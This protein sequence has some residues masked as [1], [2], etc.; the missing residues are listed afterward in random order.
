MTMPMQHSRRLT[1]STLTDDLHLVTSPVY[2]VTVAVGDLPWLDEFRCT[3]WL[4][5]PLWRH[6]LG[7][8]GFAFADGAWR[9]KKL[10][11]LDANAPLP[12]RWLQ[13]GS[14]EMGYVFDAVAGGFSLE[15]EKHV[16]M[17]CTLYGQPAA[18][19]NTHLDAQHATGTP[20]QCK[21][22]L[23]IG[24]N[25]PVIAVHK[26]R[27][28]LGA[29]IS[30]GILVG[31]KPW[32]EITITRTSKSGSNS[33]FVDLH[34]AWIAGHE[35]TCELEVAVGGQW[36]PRIKIHGQLAAPP[37]LASDAIRVQMRAYGENCVEIV[38]P[39]W[40]V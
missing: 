22:H 40:S 10:T 37:Q 3:M 24:P 34:S 9:L 25:L 20:D 21:S 5:N 17:Q 1:L 18:P 7:A 38:D 2:D 35:A 36:Q 33:L 12:S 11:M 31:V 30:H 6:L 26:A 28:D 4:D 16:Q 14:P 8:C 39:H 23:W 15:A 27:M 29:Q 32:A 19:L 13:L